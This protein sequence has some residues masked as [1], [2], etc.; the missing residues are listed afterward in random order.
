[1]KIRSQKLYS[2]LQT[3]GTLDKAPED[4]ALAKKEYRRI[5]KRNWKQIQRPRKELRIEFT[6]KQYDIIKL[7]A[8]AC[9]QRPTTYARS[10]ILS[11]TEQQ[12]HIICRDTLLLIL[13]LVS[14]AAIGASKNRMTLRE[15]A[16][17][18]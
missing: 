4:I 18:I 16:E 11:A 3:T 2:Y 6:I 17:R 10:V 15:I 7:K 12:R 13:Q 9:G 8:M 5:Y 1:M 14:R